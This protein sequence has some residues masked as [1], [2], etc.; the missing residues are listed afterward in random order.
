V[1]IVLIGLRGTGKTVCGKLLAERLG[2]RFVDTDDRVQQRAGKSIREIFSAEGE[3]GFREREAEAVR[4]VAAGEQAVIATGGGAVLTPANVTAMRDHGFVVHLAGR[5]ETL[6]KRISADPRSTALRP[7]LMKAAGGLEEMK[8]LFRE[9]A[10]AYCA[11][12]DV[13]VSV[14]ERTPEQIV[15]AILL[16]LRV[17]GIQTP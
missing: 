3:A 13:E 10:G 9:R 5:P 6:W 8:Q 15:S 1:N 12:R 11:A 17:R 16:L 14:E 4:E 2:W 7:E